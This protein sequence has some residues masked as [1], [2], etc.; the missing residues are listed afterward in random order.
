MVQ[1]IITLYGVV[2]LPDNSYKIIAIEDDSELA[3][4]PL[5]SSLSL[6]FGVSNQINTWDWNIVLSEVDATGDGNFF[7]E[8]ALFLKEDGSSYQVVDSI[9]VEAGGFVNP[10][11]PVANDIVYLGMIGPGNLPFFRVRWTGTAT[12]ATAK[13]KIIVSM[14]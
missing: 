2:Q 5:T 1:N 3:D 11:T 6:P 8:S 7:I 9:Q 12:V 14:S 13:I 4:V 10:I